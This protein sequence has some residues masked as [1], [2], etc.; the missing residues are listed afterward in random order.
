MAKKFSFRLDSILNLRSHKV[1]QEK[2]ALQQ[3]Q[4]QRIKKDIEIEECKKEL[5]NSFM[6]KSGKFSV[7]ILQQNYFRQEFLKENIVKLEKE[8]K[9]LLEIETQRKKILFEAQKEEK[10]LLKLKE[11]KLLEYKFEL[12]Q[13]DSK[14]MDEIA[15]NQIS[16]KEI[17]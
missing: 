11:K 17:D 6:E 2:E 3:I 10:I 15:I 16:K 13:E 5:E 9:R 12:D 1:K 14:V 4:S 7:E 8:K